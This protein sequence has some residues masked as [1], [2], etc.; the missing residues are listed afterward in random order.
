MSSHRWGSTYRNT[1]SF[2]VWIDDADVDSED[3]VIVFNP[4]DDVVEDSHSLRE[5]VADIC[6]AS[7]RFC[8]KR[9]AM[10]IPIA[11]VRA[12]QVHNWKTFSCKVEESFPSWAPGQIRAPSQRAAVK[13]GQRG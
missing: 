10:V 6:D 1:A 13:Y 8:R 3:I 5:T 9:P 2:S 12:T 4:V 7:I 11:K